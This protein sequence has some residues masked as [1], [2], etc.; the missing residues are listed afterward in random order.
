MRKTKLRSVRQRADCGAGIVRCRQIGGFAEGAPLAA[1]AEHE[2]AHAAARRGRPAEGSHRWND[3]SGYR[4]RCG[5]R[6]IDHH[7]QFRRT[8][9]RMQ[10]VATIVGGNT[11]LARRE[12]GQAQCGLGSHLTGAVRYAGQIRVPQDGRALAE[13]Q[14]TTGIARWTDAKT[15]G[16]PNPISITAAR[17]STSRPSATVPGVAASATST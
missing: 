11:M 14:G 13:G 1:A 12:C 10:S 3:R 4:R 6:R 8:S 5:R 9:R 17:N 2:L 7:R 15:G 16:A